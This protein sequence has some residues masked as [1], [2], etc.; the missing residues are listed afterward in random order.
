M[1]TTNSDDCHCQYP[2]NPIENMF[3]G[4]STFTCTSG[5]QKHST[6]CLSPATCKVLYQT[7]PSIQLQLFY[8]QSLLPVHHMFN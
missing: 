8:C 7:V 6:K 5:F 2:G 3:C 4:V 1:M